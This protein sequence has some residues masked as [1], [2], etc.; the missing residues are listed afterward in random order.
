VV[1]FVIRRVL[2]TIPVLLL[3]TFLTFW[4]VKG[5]PYEPY[6]NPRFAKSVQENMR[7]LHGDDKPFLVQ[8]G[9]Y[10]GDLVLRR[11]LGYSSK[12]G[13]TRISEKIDGPLQTSMLLGVLA[14]TLSAIVGITIG[15]VCAVYYNRWPDHVLGLISTLAFAVPSFFVAR[16][17]V[18]ALPYH[19]GWDTW[20]ERIGPICVLALLIM[21]YFVRLVRA[22]MIET[23]QSDFVTAARAK[24]LPWRT[25]VV[26]HVLRNSLIPTVTNAGPL[27]GFLLTGAFIIEYIMN[28][29]GIG[30]EFV[31]AAQGT[32]DTRMLLNLTVI[33]SVFI[34]TM[35]LIVDIVIAWLD[36][37]IT[38][39]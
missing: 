13:R 38:H 7:R 35:N 14:F 34:I 32:P 10:L 17:W 29:P 33:L 25:T 22:T 9:M 2:W 16:W 11:D 24:G 18:E 21:P 28:V 36:P 12:P 15:A 8:Y 3:A 26:R 39:D 20:Q 5:L 37:R 23:L 6:N 4:M 19:Q 1:G 27:L 31:Y 30:G